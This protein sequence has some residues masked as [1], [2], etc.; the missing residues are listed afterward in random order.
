[1]TKVDL[2]T[3]DD[4]LRFVAENPGRVGKREIAR[5]FAVKG[6]DRIGLKNLL[7]DMSEEGLIEKSGKRLK[8]PDDLPRV[9][10]LQVTG[11]SAD[12]DLLAEPTHWE[13]SGAVP[14]VVILAAKG[15]APAVGDRL[16]AR[17]SQDG[18]GLPTGRVIKV[19]E[20][21]PASTLAVVERFDGRPQLTPVSK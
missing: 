11:K 9:T 12:G 16:L 13:V 10:L 5:A 14:K 21:R 6:G 15:P 7:A 17:I 20:R 18:D 3:R 2:P 8:R 19:I 1:M 4:I